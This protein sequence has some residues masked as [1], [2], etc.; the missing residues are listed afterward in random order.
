MINLIKQKEIEILEIEL[1]IKKLELDVDILKDDN[2]DEELFKRIDGF[3][4]YFI[5]NFG[6]VKNSKTN[7]IMKLS[8]HKQGYKLVALCKKGKAKTFKVHRLVGIAF[9][10]NPDNKEMIDH[11]DENKANNNVKN[12]R[13]ATRNDNSANQGKYKN[14]T[15]GYKG[16]S[17]HKPAHKYQVKIR[18]NGKLKHLGYFK[19]V[20]DASKAYEAK[21]REI[22]GEF[23]Y[24]NK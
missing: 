23:Y 8:T 5:S 22:H 13:W 7:R 20:E 24:K 14:N 18:I 19:N 21:A 17:F 4:N 15:T 6:N 16:V 3:D 1:K 11:I 12:L 2:N 9:L 10:K